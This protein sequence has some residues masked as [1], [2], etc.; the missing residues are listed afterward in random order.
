MGQGP[1]N[2]SC[3]SWARLQLLGRSPTLVPSVAGPAVS[4]FVN[5]WSY[6][7]PMSHGQNPGKK[8][9]IQR[10][11]RV[12]TEGLLGSLQGACFGCFDHSSFDCRAQ[13]RMEYGEQIISHLEADLWGGL[14]L[15]EHRGLFR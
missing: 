9:S 12:L 8:G 3:S 6:G 13:L 10:L 15:S 5:S 7:L 4:V 1:I 14:E 2:N 11:H